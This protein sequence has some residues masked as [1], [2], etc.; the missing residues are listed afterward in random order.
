MVNGGRGPLCHALAARGFGDWRHLD[1]T[2]LSKKDTFPTA[3]YCANLD[4]WLVE[5]SVIS[6]CSLLAR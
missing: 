2:L 5:T 3:H 4:S 6:G 1:A